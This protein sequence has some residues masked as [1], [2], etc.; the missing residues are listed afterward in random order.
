MDIEYLGEY[1]NEF[2]FLKKEQVSAT[3]KLKKKMETIIA[4]ATDGAAD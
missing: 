2:D 3:D 4:K 1:F